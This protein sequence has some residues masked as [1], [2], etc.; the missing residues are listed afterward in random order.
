[1]REEI[2]LE[3]CREV[4]GDVV[5]LAKAK[6]K[7]RRSCGVVMVLRWRSMKVRFDRE[8]RS[9]LLTELRE[10]SRAIHARIDIV[11]MKQTA[12]TVAE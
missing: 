3:D 4:G 11:L 6:S 10:D 1:M 7:W 9:A 2:F 5:A 12:D 8:S